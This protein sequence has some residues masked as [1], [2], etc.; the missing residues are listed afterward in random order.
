M[1]SE[2]LTQTPVDTVTV[3]SNID[4]PSESRPIE[5]LQIEEEN[6]VFPT[7]PKLWSTMASMSI[8]LFLS[9]LVSCTL[10]TIADSTN[11]LWTGYHNC[12]SCC[13]KY[14]R[15]IPDNSRYWMV[16]RC[17]VSPKLFDP[18]IVLTPLQWHVPQ[19]LCL[20]VSEQ[21]LISTIN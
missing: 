6:I 10:T 12:R 17:V 7:G 20:L 16:F 15:R 3:Q 8:A 14:N 18:A 9:G 21:L 2:T 5:A 11:R 13:T 4:S 1:A 19:R